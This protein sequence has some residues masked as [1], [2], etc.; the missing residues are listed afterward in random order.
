VRSALQ[1]VHRRNVALHFVERIG[2]FRLFRTHS[3][4]MSASV[5]AAGTL[6]KLRS[7]A[8][9]AIAR[10][11]TLGSALLMFVLGAVALIQGSFAVGGVVLGLSLLI[12]PIELFALPVLVVALPD[13]LQRVWRVPHN[14]LQVY[15]FRAL[16]L[17]LFSIATFFAATTIA[18]GVFLLI[19]ALV[20]LVAD[21]VKGESG[22]LIE[23][24]PPSTTTTTTT[25]S[26]DEPATATATGTGSKKSGKGKVPLAAQDA[27]A[28]E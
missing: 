19:G 3:C 5:Q 23:P 27:L 16:L 12:V 10:Y 17:A 1:L 13:S 6:L 18:G 14:L 24:P 20:Y 11:I 7:V 15:K 26:S 25:T 2:G 28:K 22:P 8:L 4:R 9:A 21:L